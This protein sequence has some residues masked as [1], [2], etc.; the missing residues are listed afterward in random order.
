[1]KSWVSINKLKVKDEKTEAVVCGSQ[2]R[3]K[4]VLKDQICQIQVGR[5]DYQRM[6]FGQRPWTCHQFQLG[7]RDSLYLF[8]YQSPL[9]PS[10]IKTHKRLKMNTFIYM[11]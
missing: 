4:R 2:P 6:R 9:L 8:S 5:C 7:Y 10:Q 11:D 1:M 3:V